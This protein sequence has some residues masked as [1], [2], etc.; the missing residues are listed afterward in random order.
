MAMVRHRVAHSVTVEVRLLISARGEEDVLYRA[1]GPPARR[2]P[3]AFV[4]GPTSFVGR[5]VDALKQAGR[6]AAAIRA[7][8]FGP[9]GEM[10]Q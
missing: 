6:P 9:M 1:V 8:G 2:Q 4:C 10:S 3:R 7:E 5:A